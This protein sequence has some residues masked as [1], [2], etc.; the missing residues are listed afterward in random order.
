MGK[1]SF[2]M[3]LFGRIAVLVVLFMCSVT[4][5]NAQDAASWK[6]KPVT[7]RVS[8]QPL[9]KVLEMVA[10]AAN[11]KIT[12]QEVSL[13]NVNKPINLAVKNKP[14]DKVL[15]DLVGD[16]DV[17]I[18]YEGENQII[19]QPDKQKEKENKGDEVFVSGQVFDRD[20]QESL[21]GA[22][23]LITDGTG[24]N[25]GARGCQTDLDGKFSLRLNRKES[26]SISFVG[27]ETVSKQI[28]KDE[29]NLVFE[30]K[31][32]IEMA[33]VVVTGISRRSKD[34]FTGN[35]VEVKGD[36]LRK[37]SPTNILKGIQFFDP[38]FKIIENNLT[39]SDPNAEP[40]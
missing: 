36:D 14:L 3:G 40:D 13:W 7:L 11:A 15:G 12:L 24:D 1:T 38:S 22:T 10:E 35:Y 19:L 17:I 16:Q 31:P 8:N 9:G 30:L 23:V 33:E 27:Y 26:I 6:E 20:T 5:L 39:G 4:A 18:R 37:M 21:I 29:N 28:L 34:S 32:S 25:K 2:N